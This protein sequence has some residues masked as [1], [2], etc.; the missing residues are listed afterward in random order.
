MYIA[1][2]TIAAAPTTAQPQ[3]SRYTPA[4]TRNSPAKATDPGTASAMIPVV[5]S[6]VASAGRPRAIPPRPL[7]ALVPVRTSTIPASR[8]SDAET[9]PC[10]TD[11][12]I[13]PLT[14]TLVQREEAERDQPHLRHRR[15]RGHRADVG[16]PE[17]EQRPVDEPDSREG[18]DVRLEV[19]DGL[20]E[21]RDHDSQEPVDGS[22]RDDAGEN[23]GHLGRRL[24]VGLD[25]PAVE[26]EDR[27]LHRERG[28]EAQEDPLVRRRTRVDQR[29]RPLREP[30]DDDRRQHQQRAGH[31]VDDEGR[32][33]P[34]A[35]R[36]SPD[37]DQDVQRDQHR[38]EEDVEEQQVLRGED[39]DDRAEQE[40]EQ[41]VVGAAPLAVRPEPVADRRRADDDREP[42]EPEREAEEADVVGD[43]EVGEPLLPV[44]QLERLLEVEAGERRRSR[45]RARRA[46]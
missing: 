22:L 14:P 7:K 35:P 43:A 39:A 13:A 32:C 44:L 46:R 41:A 3:P 18:E 27:R 17:R 4:R 16:S 30:E 15:V 40:Q 38:L 1:A 19:V 28:E 12:R 31:R 9:R 11:C 2:R 21:L 10:A 23:C 5:I 34:Q 26:G 33:R 6:T 8:K 42:G 37:A 24:A 36:A 25:E 20:G 29:E 45:A